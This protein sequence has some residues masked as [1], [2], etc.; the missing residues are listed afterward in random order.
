M[1]N[2]LT[3]G[4]YPVSLEVSG[5]AG[6]DQCTTDVTVIDNE[7]PTITCQTDFI[8][9]LTY[10]TRLTMDNVISTAYDNCYEGITK[11]IQ[12]GIPEYTCND[13]GSINVVTGVATDASGNTATC[14]VTITVAD[15]YDNC[16]TPALGNPTVASCVATKTFDADP[17]MCYKDIFALQA[18][19]F[20]NGSTG[21]NI[22]FSFPD[23]TSPTVGTTAV[24]VQVSGD[25][26]TDYCETQVTVN[27]VEAPT[28]S[29]YDQWIDVVNYPT[30]YP[31]SMATA[32]DNCPLSMYNSGVTITA[33]GGLP[34]F[35]CQHVGT[36]QAVTMTATDA[37]GN[38]ASCALTVTVTDDMYSCSPTVASCVSA[39]TINTDP[40]SC[41]G[42]LAENALD[43]G[44]TGVSISFMQQNTY[45]YSGTHTITTEVHGLG[46]MDRCDTSVTVIDNE[47]PVISCYDFTYDISGN[48]YF[49]PSSLAWASDN[50]WVSGT[51]T[52]AVS[53]QGGEPSFGC[54]DVGTFQSV[55]ME[56]TDD[57]GNAAT[58]VSAVTVTDS[59]YTC[60]PTV[61]SCV[62]ALTY[63]TDPGMCYKDLAYN[64]E[65]FDN[66]SSGDHI[67]KYLYNTMPN[68]GTS[69]VTLEVSGSAGMDQCTTDVTIVDNEPPT[70]SCVSD[71]TYYVGYSAPLATWDIITTYNDNCWDGL[72]PSLQAADIS[73]ACSDVDNTYTVT[74]V[75]TDSSGNT[76]TCDVPVTVLDTTGCC[77]VIGTVPVPRSE[78]NPPGA[79]PTGPPPTGPS[80]TGPT[81]STTEG[82]GDPHF[83]TWTNEHF[84]FHGQCDLVM[85][86][87]PSFADD[88]GLDVHLRTKLV[89]FW[90]YIKT[91]AIRIGNDILEIE[92]WS[93]ANPARYWINYEY[94]GELN[95]L[96]GFPVS[97]SSPGAKKREYKIDL[98]SKYPGQVILVKVFKEFVGVRVVNGSEEA[99]GKTVGIVGDFKTGNTLARDGVTVIDDFSEL[100]NEW[101]VLP[102]DCKLFHETETPQFPELCIMPEDPRGERRRRLEESSIA[103]EEAESAC[104]GLKDA[105]TIKD[106]VYDIIATQ[107]LD[108]V[109]AF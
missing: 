34:T 104:A 102:S 7:P 3:V 24:T 69:S 27:D 33:D 108:M 32:Y 46:G 20:D 87:D 66:G 76:A 17:G 78:V 2:S 28:I 18:N 93:D 61:A 103:M 26:G 67:Y 71:F 29:C 105:A 107:Q 73:Y 95:E 79:S 47:P 52:D 68:V 45:P 8:Y 55:T 80:P 109:G 97:T 53:F 14:D 6:M 89:R 35:G 44:S 83:T 25:G 63:N 50:C 64:V 4:T 86:S 77:A 22:W 74:G 16:N 98:G 81:G 11:S 13:V 84:E 10:Y 75:V 9:D 91:A 30:L 21:D 12:G 58:C 100:G 43:D 88:I 31:A 23:Y 101:Q 65:D 48:N 49:Y 38:A 96:G 72:T 82:N 90:S 42:T 51:P 70:I 94:Q 85:M 19:T 92:G 106:C 59:S 62:S 57:S 99:F 37:S 41:H 5:S 54:A 36:P 39:T 1:I 40:G 56:V 15:S 60:S